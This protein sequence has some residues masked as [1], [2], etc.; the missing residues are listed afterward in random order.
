MTTELKQIEDK[1]MK[2]T[3]IMYIPKQYVLRKKELQILHILRDGYYIRMDMV[4]FLSELA[5]VG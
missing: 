3:E 2:I 5:K 1:I 4:Y